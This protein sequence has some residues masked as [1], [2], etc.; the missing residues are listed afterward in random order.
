MSAKDLFSKSRA[1]VDGKANRGKKQEM[2]FTPKY[3]RRF[4]E[5]DQAKPNAAKNNEKN[6]DK[7]KKTEAGKSFFKKFRKNKNA[8]PKSG[9]QAPK[10][11]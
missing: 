4:E 8:K 9:R 11:R 7:P 5:G 10:R 6:V 2:N 1:V 3:S